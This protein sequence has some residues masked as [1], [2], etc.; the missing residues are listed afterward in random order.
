[1]RIGKRVWMD[2]LSIAC[3]SLAVIGYFFQFP[4]SMLSSMI[5]PGM[6]GYILLQFPNY[7]VLKNKKYIS[8][9]ILFAAY[10]AFSVVRALALGISSGRVLRFGAIL[11]LL[12]LCCIVR[13]P[14]FKIKW[15]VFVNLAMVK[16]IILVGIMLWLLKEGDHSVIRYWVME[17][18]LGDIYLLSRWNAKVQVQGNALLLVAF[19][20]DFMLKKRFT[21]RN[22]IILGGILAAGNFAYVLG[23]G[24]FLGWRMCRLG[25]QLLRNG[26]I[27]KKTVAIVVVCCIIVVT[28]YVVHKVVQKAEVSNKTRIE[29]AGVLLDANPLIGDGLGNYIKAETSTRVYDGDIYFELQTFYV[30][31]QVGAVGLLLG[32]LLTLWPVWKR[33]KRRTVL[34]LIYLAYSFWN[35]YCWDVAHI[36]TLLLLMNTVG[37]GARYEESDYYSVLSLCKGQIEHLRNLRAGR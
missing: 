17:N 21:L 14:K 12:P 11:F 20:S 5:V 10:I 26:K 18:Q 27:S 29:Q 23:L 8:L 1:M 16:A 2:S 7:Y 30:F 37:L 9:C 22:I 28:P 13:D 19:I 35:P 3:W 25:Y 31:N 4:F 33:G 24:L 15:N 34:Y 32:Y 6:I 36:I